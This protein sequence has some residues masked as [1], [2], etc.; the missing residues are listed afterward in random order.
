[1]IDIED[2]TSLAWYTANT[3]N[4]KHLQGVEL[5]DL[6]QAALIGIWIA[7]TKYDDSLGSFTTFA[8]K[9]MQGEI[10]GLVYR[11]TTLEGKKVRVPRVAETLVGD[12]D[13]D[14][15][16]IEQSVYEDDLEDI[17]FIEQYLTTLPLKEEY[18]T[19]FKDMILHGDR[20]ATR[21]YIESKGFSRQRA[22]QIRKA[23]RQTAQ[24]HM[25]RL[26]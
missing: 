10:S 1:M 23:I 22:E 20:E 11:G 15:D 9:Y 19:Y 16:C 13:S 8:Q 2:Y 24:R 18:M 25:E 26:Q 5:D 12:L 6:Y 21:L 7:S 3:S 17:E 14:E 4:K